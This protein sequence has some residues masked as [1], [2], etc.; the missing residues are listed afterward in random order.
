ANESPY[1]VQVALVVDT[2]TDSDL[3]RGPLV[4]VDANSTATYS[5]NFATQP[6]VGFDTGDG[7]IT[8]NARL[9]SLLFYTPTVPTSN[10]LDITVDNIRINNPVDMVAPATPKPLSFEQGV[11]SGQAILRWQAV[12]DADLAN[13][14][15]YISSD[16]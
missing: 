4:T 5:W 12:A 8:G 1:P 15:I 7:V 9:K 16:A 6:P 11:A 13:Y 14:N 2:A 10:E 3:E